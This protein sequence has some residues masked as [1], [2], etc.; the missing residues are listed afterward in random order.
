MSLNNIDELDTGY[1]QAHRKFKGRGVGKCRITVST[2]VSTRERATLTMIASVMTIQA[3]PFR[4]PSLG[5]VEGDGKGD[6]YSDVV[7]QIKS[8]LLW[9]KNHCY[10]L[11]S[12]IQNHFVCSFIIDGP[13][14]CFIFNY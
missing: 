12:C 13:V 4:L 2:A 6:K 11:V 3:Q 9:I 8:E 7:V 1:K 10:Q 14:S 5:Y